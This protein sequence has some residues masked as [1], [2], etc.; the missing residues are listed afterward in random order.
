MRALLAMIKA[1]LKMTVRNRQA[2]FWN[3][4][5]PGIFIL[6]FGSIFSSDPSIEI[7]AAVVG[8]ESAL[9]TATLSAMNAS[10]AFKISTMSEEQER[11][12]LDDGDRDVLLVFG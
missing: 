10:D 5:F 1:N 4:A 2:I 7:S 8:P 11:S 9:K 6:I 12:K 3:L